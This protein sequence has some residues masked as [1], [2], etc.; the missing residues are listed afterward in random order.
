MDV[1]PCTGSHSTS[2]AVYAV[3]RRSFL[4]SEA[5][6]FK[7]HPFINNLFKLVK[8]QTVDVFLPL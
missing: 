1:A 7:L 3:Q 5:V 8:I 6:H 2:V 4:H